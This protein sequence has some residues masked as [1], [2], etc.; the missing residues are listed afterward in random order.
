MF[1]DSKAPMGYTACSGRST[2]RA[3]SLSDT[4]LPILLYFAKQG[5]VID[6]RRLAPA[7]AEQALMHGN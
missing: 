3:T 5:N 7:E 1:C 4:L 2:P 6:R